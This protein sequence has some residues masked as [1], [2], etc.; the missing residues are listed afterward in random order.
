MTLYGGFDSLILPELLRVLLDEYAFSWED[1]AAIIAQCFIFKAEKS[2]RA[3]LAA[4]AALSPRVLKLAETVGDKLAETLWK[5]FPGDWE[6][7]ASAAVI[8]D[9][10]VD[11]GKLCAAL[12]GR[13]IC[14]KEKRAGEFRAFYVAMPNKFEDMT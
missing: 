10:E 8:W 11:F 3:P 6:R 7:V 9:G 1:A 5:V 4:V 2:E 14:P 13:I 12:C